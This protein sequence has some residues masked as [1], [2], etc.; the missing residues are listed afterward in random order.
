M[1]IWFVNEAVG[2]SAK[3]TSSEGWNGLEQYML[4]HLVKS[5]KI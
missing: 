3:Q 2:S 1:T 4:F 5:K